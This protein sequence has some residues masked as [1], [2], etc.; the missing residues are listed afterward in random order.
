VIIFDGVCNL[1]NAAVRFIIR[2]DPQARF[3]FAALQS[4]PAQALLARVEVDA[5]AFDSVMLVED[6][7]VHSRS[8]AALRVARRLRF[9]WPLL[10]AL[11][12][13]PRPLRDSLYDFI[14]RNRYRWFG[15]RETCMTPT[16]DLQSRFL[17]S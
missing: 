5:A 11:V 7:V 1:C 6:G 8:D 10:Y 15:K 9:P 14:A 2:R 16:P 17:A 12:I 4:A 3:R 13:L